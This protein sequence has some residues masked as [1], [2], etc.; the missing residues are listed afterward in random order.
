MSRIN[1]KVNHTVYLGQGHIGDKL[2]IGKAGYIYP[3][4]PGAAGVVSDVTGG[5][6]INHGAVIGGSHGQVVG[7]TGIELQAQGTVTNSGGITGGYGGKY[8]AGGVG[9]N[10][11]AGGAITNSGGIFGGTG[12]YSSAGGNGV[13][14]LAGGTLTNHSEIQGGGGGYYV[15]GT[16]GNNGTGGIGVYLKAAATVANTRQILGGNG[17]AQEGINGGHSG[18][19]G[20]G[21]DF[22]AGGTL[23]NSGLI[24]GGSSAYGRVD[25]GNGGNGATLN[26]V[27]ATNSGTIMGGYGGRA[28]EGFGGSGGAGVVMTGGTLTSMGV[29]TGG[30][31]AEG[32][33]EGP[34]RAGAGVAVYAGVVVNSGDITG[35]YNGAS[36]DGAG[37]AGVFGGGSVINSGVIIGGAGNPFQNYSDGGVGVD[38]SGGTLTNSG[39]IT[40]GTGAYG[41]GDAVKLG[42][43]STLVVDPGAVFNGNVVAAGSNDKLVLAAGPHAGQLDNLGEPGFAGFTTVAELAGATWTLTGGINLDGTKLSTAGTLTFNGTVDGN[44]SVTLDSGSTVTAD[45]ALGVASVVFGAGGAEVLALGE[46]TAVT[47]T[48]SGFAAGD[49]IDLVK[50]LAN[51]VSFSNG[52]LSLLE[53]KSVV[54][55][56]TLAGNYTSANFTLTSDGHGGTDIGYVAQ[57]AGPA[58]TGVSHELGWAVGHF[59]GPGETQ[60]GLVVAEHGHFV[61]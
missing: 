22:A 23:T 31:G 52:T 56:L 28:Y 25:G 37:G 33:N 50:L 59:A 11:A 54:A 9:I 35:G 2:V 30:A 26:N 27:T 36:G 5:Q 8:S 46:P 7:G 15:Y 42:A 12:G 3:T 1:G 47:S 40:G 17:Q 61:V 44:R 38:L 48:L 49:T 58:S 6:V 45:G 43:G 29:I 24:S 10:L 20:I 14:L 18:T 55:S 34:G 60:W 13:D 51:G 19:G 32:Y 16:S 39:T 4:T 21:I 53:N 41:G 57:A